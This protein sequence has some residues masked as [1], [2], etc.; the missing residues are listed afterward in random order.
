MQ[1]YFFG[2]RATLPKKDVVNLKAVAAKVGLAPC[3]VSATLNDTQAARAIPQATKDRVYRVAGELNYRPNLTARSLRTQRTR[4]VA[5]LAPGLSRSAVARVVAAAQRR[6]HES[7]YMLVLAACDDGDRMWAQFRQR[8]I[9]GVISIEANVPP[10]LNLPVTSV[11]LDYPTSASNAD[12]LSSPV[13]EIGD[14]AAKLSY[15]RSRTTAAIKEKNCA[16][17]PPHR[18]IWKHR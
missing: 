7:G 4:M 14:A 10:Q 9:E 18:C 3:S 13:S 6:L 12:R 17:L 11:E 5:I 1:N 15:S 2:R 16:L 8:G